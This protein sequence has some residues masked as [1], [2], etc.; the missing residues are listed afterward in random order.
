MLIAPCVAAKVIVVIQNENLFVG[1]M[2][3]AIKDCRRQS[4]QAR[5]DDHKIIVFISFAH[6]ISAQ[7][8][9]PG[10]LMCHGVGSWV[11][12]PEAGQGRGVD[13]WL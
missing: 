12:P 7:T 4:T 11:A 13:R 2:L 10:V 8:A 9:A 6:V 5:A 3:L 1:S